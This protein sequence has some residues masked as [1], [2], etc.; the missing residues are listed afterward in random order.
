VEPLASRLLQGEV[1][2]TVLEGAIE[3]HRVLG[4]GLLENAYRACLVREL[5]LRG[6]RVEDEVAVPLLYK[7]T[8]VEC[9]FRLDLV[10][11]ETVVVELKAVDRLLPIHDAQLLTY[12]KLSH[13][14]V[15]LLINFNA[16]PLRTGFRRLV[17]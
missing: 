8:P 1:T 6:L 13:R 16:T 2:G 4:P 15:G 7:D 3:V 10:V 5:R 11:E 14:R 9:G 12:L 17:L